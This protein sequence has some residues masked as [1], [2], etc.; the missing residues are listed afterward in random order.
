[1]R[2]KIDVP[3]LGHSTPIVWDDHVFLTTAVPFGEAIEPIA[4]KAPGTH[5]GVPVTHRHKFLVLAIDREDGKI[6]W[7]RALKEALPFE[8]GHYTASLASPSP[9]TDGERVFASF[10]SYGIYALDLSGDLVWKAEIGEMQ[11][12][13]GHGEGSS[14]VLHGD[15]LALNWDHEG[16]SLVAAFDKRTGKERFR[17][18]RDEVTSW[19]TPIVVEQGDRAQLIVSGT[20]RVRGYDIATGK[21]IWECGGLSAN[22]VASPVAGDGMVFAGSSYDKRALLAIRTEGAQG[23]ITGSDRVAWRRSRGT[24]YVPSPVLYQDALYFLTHYQGIIT[25]VRAKTGEERPGAVRLDGIENVYAS[26]VA[27][28][29]RVYVT[30]LEGTTVVIE[31]GDAPRVVAKNKLDDS[32]AASAAI[33]GREIFLRGRRSLYSIARP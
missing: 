20:K 29:G 27:A 28:A 7:Q 2:W 1:V 19:A 21:A 13:H 14:P 5:D 4:S 32:F 22:V 18:L 12:L 25:R 16:Q 3:G 33:A 23:D 11:T 30:D 26:P 31:D 10:G 24:P 6:L 8:G 15:T 17:V 9:V